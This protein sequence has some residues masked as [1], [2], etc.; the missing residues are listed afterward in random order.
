MAIDLQALQSPM[1]RGRG[2]GRYAEQLALAIED[3]DPTLVGAYLLNPRFDPPAADEALVATGKLT[4]ATP[5]PEHC[6]VLHLCSPVDPAVPL[7]ELWRPECEGRG[8]A[9]SA[10]VYDLIPITEAS[11]AI[12]DSVE[13]RRYRAR[14]ELLHAADGL[15]VLSTAVGTQLV[16]LLGLPA[17]RIVRVGAAAHPRFTPPVS[18]DAARAVALSRLAAAGLSR[19]FVFSPSGS[20]PRKNNERL[21][22]AFAASAADGDGFQLLVSADVDEPTRHHYRHL[23]EELG[24]GR[25][26]V[27]TG[28][29]DDGTQLACYQGAELVCVPSLAEGYGLPIAESLACRTP[30]IASDRP[31]LD[32]LLPPQLRFDPTDVSAI[33]AALTAALAAAPTLP[34]PPEP[35]EKVAGRSVAALRALVDAAPRRRTNGRSGRRRRPRLAV[36]TPLPPAATGVAG[37]SVRLIEALV[38]SEKVQVDAYVEGDREALVPGGVGCYAARALPRVEAL[39]GRYD[40]VVYAFGNSHHHLDALALLAER[41]GIVLAHDVRLSNL[42][43]HAHG[44]PALRPGG[45]ALALRAMYPELPEGAGERVAELTPEPPRAPR[46]G[47]GVAAVLRAARMFLVSSSAAAALAATDALAGDGAKIAVLPFALG[48]VDE[49]EGL[50]ADGGCPVPEGLGSVGGAWGAPPPELGSAPLVASFGIVDPA[51]R[52]QLLI[53]GFAALRRLLPQAQLALVGP[54]SEQSSAQRA[55]PSLAAELG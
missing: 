39:S 36:V 35:W 9:L 47:D 55:S 10:T 30:V 8:I 20:H 54:I 1:S 19:R 4:P 11:S 52:P 25:A 21:I 32:E 48:E 18:R 24:V 15:Q 50:F 23:A 14:L 41:P 12:T 49:R 46:G 43:R 16:E 6:R 2:I 26:L 44:D 53:R 33:A 37:Y 3:V 34:P 38:A 45:F 42:Y 29:L 27:L 5:L 22:A 17:E 13:L 7:D 51:K 40:E 31:P 28:Y